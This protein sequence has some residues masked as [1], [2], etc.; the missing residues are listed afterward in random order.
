MAKIESLLSLGFPVDSRDHHGRTPLMMAVLEDKREAVNSLLDHGAN[1]LLEDNRKRSS[2][3]HVAK[4]GNIAMID[5]MLSKGR[6]VNSRKNWGKVPLILAVGNDK[7]SMTY[8]FP[9]KP[10]STRWI[11]ANETSTVSP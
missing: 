10:K 3:H 1:P 7:Q 6:A 9:A 2:I 11:I 8:I 4:G 5:L